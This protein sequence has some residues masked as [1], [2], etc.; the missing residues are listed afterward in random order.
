MQMYK[1]VAHAAKVA[2]PLLVVNADQDS[3]CLLQG[4][5]DYAKACPSAEFVHIDCGRSSLRFSGRLSDLL[6]HTGHFDI[7]P[8]QP[9]HEQALD[10]QLEFLKRIVP[11]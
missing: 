6:R 7:Y 5:L 11:V 9:S 3:I 1:P 4:A 8:R 10:A 2:C